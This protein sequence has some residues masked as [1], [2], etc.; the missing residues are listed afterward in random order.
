M[1]YLF[2]ERARVLIRLEFWREEDLPNHSE[3]AGVV[4][5]VE[6]PSEAFVGILEG[7]DAAL[8]AGS[9]EGGCCLS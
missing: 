1:A 5:V 4:F 2:R 6:I 3:D 8:G 9:G 7:I